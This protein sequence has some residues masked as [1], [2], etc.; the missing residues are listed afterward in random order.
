[1]R[2]KPP[3]QCLHDELFFKS[4]KDPNSPSFHGWQLPEAAVIYCLRKSGVVRQVW[5]DVFT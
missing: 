2:S 1:M 3:R 5:D 4:L